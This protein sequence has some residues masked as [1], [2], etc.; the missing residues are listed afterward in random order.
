MIQLTTGRSVPLPPVRLWNFIHSINSYTT[1]VESY[2]EHLDHQAKRTTFEDGDDLELR[3]IVKLLILIHEQYKTESAD[4]RRSIHRLSEVFI[5]QRVT[6]MLHRHPVI[7]LELRTQFYR[8]V[9]TGLCQDDPVKLSLNESWG[10][11]HPA[12]ILRNA[13]GRM[14]PTDPQTAPEWPGYAHPGVDV[15]MMFSFLLKRSW[16]ANNPAFRKRAFRFLELYEQESGIKNIRELAARRGL[17]I[18]CFVFFRAGNIVEAAPEQI[19]E[20][21]FR[22]M[23]RMIQEGTCGNE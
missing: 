19:R 2:A 17:P 15:G 3:T 10:D 9:E 21:L 8:D 5:L 23:H 16:M 14:E 18:A 20:P 12:N 7:S 11:F 22:E 13:D 1:G 4:E 6:E